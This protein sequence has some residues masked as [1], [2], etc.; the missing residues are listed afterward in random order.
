L[1]VFLLHLP[2]FL[3]HESAVSMAS[4]PALR[5]IVERGLRLKKIGNRLMTILGGREIH[6]VSVCV[7]GFY[8]APAPSELRPLLPELEWGI[9]AAAQ[10]LRWAAALEFPAFDGRIRRPIR[11]R[12]PVPPG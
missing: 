10:T 2:D 1:H 4:D 9:E 12:F 5:P 6:T 11:V 7:G 3:G 8:R